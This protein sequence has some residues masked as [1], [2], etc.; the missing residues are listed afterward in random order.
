MNRSRPAWVVVMRREVMAKLTDRAFLVGTGVTIALIVGLLGVQ[1]F[2]SERT[3]SYELVATSTSRSMADGVAR[4]ATTS[5]DK[6]EVTVSTAPDAAAARAAVLDGDADVWLHHDNGTWVVTGRNEVPS[7]LQTATQETVRSTVLADNA[8]SA[9]TTV[10]ALQK[11]STVTVDQLV[12]SKDKTNLAKAVGFAMAFLFYIAAIM[13]GVTLASSVVEE[14]QSRIV[15][16]IAAAI[17]VRQLLIGKVLG[18]SL[19]ALVQIIVYAAI[20]LVGLSF[21]S[22]GNLLPSVT[23]PILW[24]VLFFAVGFLAI[25]CLYAATGA[26]ASRTEDLQSTSMPV[27]MF[28]VVVFLGALLLTGQWQTIGSFVPPLSAILMP[29][30][31]LQGGV[32][33]WEPLVALVGLLAF[34]A[35]ALWVGERIYRRSLLQ[36]GGRVSLRSAWSA[37]G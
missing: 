34:S 3:T 12:G 1:A 35:T 20:G 17:P 29:T 28:L 23:G 7:S 31:M 4:T 2:L 6:V 14:K 15:E 19:I 22:F 26:L 13:F 27:T 36:T 16:I 32:A 10:D 18:N 9:G 37:T 11:G 8:R 5:G 30:R 25:A 21:T 33:P 24:F